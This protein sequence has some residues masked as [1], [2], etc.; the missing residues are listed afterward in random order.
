VLTLTAK[1]E[2]VLVGMCITA[3]RGLERVARAVLD[4]DDAVTAVLRA[5]G[6]DVDLFR[7]LVVVL[8]RHDAQRWA[9]YLLDLVTE[10]S[11]IE[12]GAA[13]R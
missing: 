5:A 4:R 10:V 11:R 3:S 7:E 12:S 2:R 8:E 9:F 13:N 6:D 1:D